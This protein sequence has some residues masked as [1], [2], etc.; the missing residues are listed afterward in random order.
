MSGATA[1]SFSRSRDILTSVSRTGRIESSKAITDASDWNEA[2]QDSYNSKNERGLASYDRRHIFVLSYIYPIPF[3]REQNAWYK[4]A[5]GGWELSGITTLQSGRPLNITLPGDVA[6]TGTTGQRPN[7]VGDPYAGAGTRTRSFD[8]AAFAAPSPG[9]FGNLGRN[10]IIDPGTNNWDVSLSK[11]FQ[12]GERVRTEF[13]AEVYNAP[14]HFSYFGVATTLGASN[15][16]PVTSANDPRT[17]QFGLRV[18]F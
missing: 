17:F 3:W 8:P 11:I 13:R 16:G 7:L 5:F 4:Y 12:I 15:F 9:T 6:G 1:T 10:A 14:H 2:P 18:R